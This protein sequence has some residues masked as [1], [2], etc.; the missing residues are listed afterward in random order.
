MRHTLTSFALLSAIFL[1]ACT[2]KT[3]APAPADEQPVAVL[4][5]REDSEET[6]PAVTMDQA[7]QPCSASETGFKTVTVGPMTFELPVSWS[8]VNR[9][10]IAP[11]PVTPDDVTYIHPSFRRYSFAKNEVIYDDLN[12]TQ[13]DVIFTENDSVI[14]TFIERMKNDPTAVE[15][16]DHWEN[17]TIGGQE[18]IVQVLKKNPDGSV[19]KGATGG[20]YTYLPGVNMILHKQSY[21][22]AAFEA[23]FEHFLKSVRF[24]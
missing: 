3:P 11:M 17:Q 22:D 9:G 20:A 5:T 14:P 15:N 12:W 19:D 16:T 10:D 7:A 23:G 21:G 8:V 2:Q 4:D 18:A 24:E 6:T 1:S 13:V